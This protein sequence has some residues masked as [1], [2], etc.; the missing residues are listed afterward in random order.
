MAIPMTGE[1]RRRLDEI[2]SPSY[3]DELE[4]ASPSDLRSKLREARMEEDALSYVRRNL[5]G[6]LDL[7]RAE[8]SRRR[9]GHGS[10]RSVEALTAVL[11]DQGS[12]QRIGRAGLSLR[13]AAVAAEE[14]DELL[15]SEDTL[16][17]LPDLSEE[18]IEQVVD[19]VGGAER[20]LSDQRRRL[21]AVIDH[22]EAEMASRYKAGLEPSLERLQ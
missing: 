21:H 8:L 11:A 3:L 9:G 13:A 14:V 12:S 20:R 16:A 18:E 4:M 22:I 7:L 6:R 1:Q 17:R 5:H 10:A 2:L 19:R 15:L